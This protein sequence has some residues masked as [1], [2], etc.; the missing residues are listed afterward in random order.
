MLSWYIKI[1][2]IKLKH[3]DCWKL[4]DA[5]IFCVIHDDSQLTWHQTKHTV[6]FWRPSGIC[7]EMLCC[8]FSM[9][10]SV[11]LK[12]WELLFFNSFQKLNNLTSQYFTQTYFLF[13]LLNGTDPS[14]IS[15][16]I[17]SWCHFCIKLPDTTVIAKSHYIFN[18]HL[19]QLDI[20]IGPV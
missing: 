6:H 20:L 14:A 1:L 11:K 15:S 9:S 4:D 12:E 7:I 3:S 16:Y 2:K 8:I 5:R 10:Q 18:A 13:L 19:L 17:A